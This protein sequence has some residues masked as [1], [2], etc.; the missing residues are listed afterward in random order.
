MVSFPWSDF[1]TLATARVR[2]R[3][4]SEPDAE[5]ILRL[6]GDAEVQRY[7]TRPMRSVVQALALVSTM[8][9]WYRHAQAIQWG[10]TIPPD[11][12]VVGICG[13]HDWQPEQ[14]QAMLGYDLIRR[15]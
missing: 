6:R 12:H 3:Q 15:H 8:Q 4:I 10:I 9:Y 2:L 7:N 13:L 1:P 5:D 14:R 11:N